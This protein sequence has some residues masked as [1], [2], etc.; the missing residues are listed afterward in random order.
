MIKPNFSQQS[1]NTG[2][3]ILYH[4]TKH[5]DRLIQFNNQDEA[6]RKKDLEKLF[7]EGKAQV[8]DGRR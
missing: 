1:M 4:E 2:K 6:E 7:G 3:S 5:L 8:I